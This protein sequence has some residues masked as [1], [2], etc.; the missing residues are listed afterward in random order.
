MS[1]GHAP[2]SKRSLE[3]GSKARKEED[4]ER[5]FRSRARRDWIEDSLLGFDD[6]S[7]DLY[8]GTA[9]EDDLDDGP[10]ALEWW[11]AAE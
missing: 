1:F 6:G 11:D 4:R 9:L 7:D 8:A 10:E 5:G 3:W 2:L